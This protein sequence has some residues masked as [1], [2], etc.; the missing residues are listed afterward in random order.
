LGDIAAQIR[1]SRYTR[2]PVYHKNI[3]KVFGLLHLRK[4]LIQ[5]TQSD[6]TKDML[7]KC[8]DKAYFV[9]A[10]MP[11]HKL[12]LNFKRDNLR[13]GLVVDEYG[14]VL[15]L[16]TLEDVLQ[17]IVGGFTPDPTDIV[18]AKDGSYWVNAGLSLRELNRITGWTLPT[19]GPKTLNG[20][21]IEY[22]E[23]IPAPG[24]NLKLGELHLEITKIENN[25][26]RM[27]R[28]HP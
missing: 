7:T 1:S 11:L 4:A 27:V 12:L 10:N 20:L 9:P 22:L 26:I 21:I 16:V 15:G 17:E 23:T 25:V 8:L 18:K 19:E 2:L 13:M 3:D 6:F 5:M 28:F 14:D 24:T